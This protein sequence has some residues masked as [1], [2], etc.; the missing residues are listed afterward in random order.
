MGSECGSVCCSPAKVN[1]L[2]QK[3]CQDFANKTELDVDGKKIKKKQTTLKHRK[4]LKGYGSDDSEDDFKL[5]KAAVKKKADPKPRPAVAGPSKKA[6]DDERP[7]AAPK[8]AP[9][10]KAPTKA[11]SE[12]DSDRDI[13]MVDSPA[14][15]AKGKGK[16]K[17]EEAPK[18]KSYVY[19]VWMKLC[20]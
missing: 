14:V 18:R 4:S 11:K 20:D 12:V 13:E 15:Q 6:S 8:K 19:Y 9:V 16:A 3:S 2:L 1:I 5:P 17:A 10:K 7:A